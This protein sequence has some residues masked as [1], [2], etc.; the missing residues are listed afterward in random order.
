MRLTLTQKQFDRLAWP[1]ADNEAEHLEVDISGDPKNVYVSLNEAWRVLRPGG[2]L[3]LLRPASGAMLFDWRVVT[4]EKPWQI[5][6]REENNGQEVFVLTPVKGPKLKPQELPT[7][8]AILITGGIGDAIVLESILEPAEREKVQ[9]IYYACPNA[10]TIKLIFESLPNY[11]RLKEHI[12]LPTGAKVFNDMNALVMEGYGTVPADDYSIVKIFPQEHRRYV[13]S[14]L[15]TYRLSEPPS[16]LPENFIVVIP[17]SSWGF[18]KDRNFTFTDWQVCLRFLEKYDLFGVMLYQGP[19]PID[20]KHPRL[21]NLSNQLD[22]L[23][24]VEVMRRAQGYMGI[25]SALSVLAPKLYPACRIAIKSV[26]EHL[27][28]WKHV[29]YLPHKDFPFVNRKLTEPIWI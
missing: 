28:H 4:S 2:N 15:L 12:V 16:D 10:K 7:K 23:E 14:S 6:R 27:Y 18:W 26:W 9:K 20:K 25:D 21:I 13:G 8:W 22:I 11:P 3:L 5:L 19:E 29:Y 17:Q 24:A 1:E